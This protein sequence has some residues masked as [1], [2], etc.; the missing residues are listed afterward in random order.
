MKLYPL[1]FIRS[2]DGMGG[3]LDSGC[4]SNPSTTN[5]NLLINQPG[6]EEPHKPNISM[7]KKMVL[8]KCKKI[9]L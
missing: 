9:Y 2:S 8:N 5:N 7:T 4:S 1:L 6:K 3:F